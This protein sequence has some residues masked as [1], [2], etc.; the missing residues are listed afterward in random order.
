[1]SNLAYIRHSQQHG[2]AKVERILLDDKFLWRFTVHGK[3]F[4][5][6]NLDQVIGVALG[7]K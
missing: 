5:G 4:V 1:M 7:K 3:Q 6:S 2:G